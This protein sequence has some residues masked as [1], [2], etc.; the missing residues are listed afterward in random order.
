MNAAYLLF[1]VKG[2]KP[3][4]YIEM[5]PGERLI[6]RA[7]LHQEIKEKEEELKKIKSK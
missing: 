4:D 2:W 5:G 3:S 6:T 7:F 1:R